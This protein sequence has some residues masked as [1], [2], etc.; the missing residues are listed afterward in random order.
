MSGPSSSVLVPKI[1]SYISIINF[2][3]LI[4]QQF[5]FLPGYLPV[6]YGK[7]NLTKIFPLLRG[8]TIPDFKEQE[9]NPHLGINHRFVTPAK[10]TL[11]ALI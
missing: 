9:R 7:H 11:Q 3:A 10:F 8:R 2:D 1:T 4:A 5:L 6:G